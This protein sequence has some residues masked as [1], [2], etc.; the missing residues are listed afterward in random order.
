M[1]ANGKSNMDKAFQRPT[2]NQ[3]EYDRRLAAMNDDQLLSELQR[4][5]E[6]I[7]NEFVT[8]PT[9]SVSHTSAND[10][11][12]QELNHRASQLLNQVTQTVEGVSIDRSVGEGKGIVICAGGFEYGTDALIL[13]KLLRKHGCTTG[14]EIWHKT[15]EMCAEMANAFVQMNCI[16]RDISAVSS[17]TFPNRFAIKPLAVF[18]SSFQQVLLLDADNISVGNPER[19]FD[20]LSE[21]QP[22]VFWPDHWPLDKHALCYK[23]LTNEQVAKLTHTM[24][25]DSGQLLIDKKYCMKEISVCI[26]INVQLHS[27]LK[28]LFP[29]PFNGGDK[30]T[31]NFAWIKTNTAFTMIPHRPGGVGTLDAQGQYIGTTLVQFDST[32]KPVFLHKMRAKW[33]KETL[34]PQWLEVVRFLQPYPRGRVHQWTQRFEDGPIEKGKFSQKFGDLEDECWEILNDLRQTEWYTRTFKA[35]MKDIGIS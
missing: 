33:A 11:T 19:L 29:E 16:V 28:R 24:A 31:W 8:L 26:R 34:K 23:T 32:H 10:P 4:V 2:P 20:M 35:E 18:H 7:E 25:Q 17:I 5:I 21:E 1:L 22:A 9:Q 30:D 13:V 15:D 3:T 6:H 14:I 27:Q 12:E